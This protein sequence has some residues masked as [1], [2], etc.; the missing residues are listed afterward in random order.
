VTELTAGIEGVSIGVSHISELHER[1]FSLRGVPWSTLLLLVLAS[2]LALLA[3]G[4][5]AIATFGLAT[6]D[7]LVYPHNAPQA[8][9]LWARWD[10]EWYLLIAD[11]GY[12]VAAFTERF[13]VPYSAADATGFFPLYPLL[14]RVL[15]PLLG[16]V[17]AGVLLSNLCLLAGLGCLYALARAVTGEDQTSSAGLVACLAVLL[18]PMSF[19]C[20]A[21]YAESLFLLLVAGTLL[22]LAQG[23]FPAAGLVVGLASLARPF[24]VLL[25][26]PWLWEW[27]RQKHSAVQYGRRRATWSTLLWLW[28][29][30][31][32][33]G[34]FLLYCSNLLG[35][36]LAFAHR[37]QRWRG[38]LSGPW[39]GFL[40]WWEAGPTLHGGA[41]SSLEL[42]IVVA[43]LC[44]L[45]LVIRKLPGAWSAFA[46]ILALLPLCSSLW[47]YGRLSLGLVPVY[48]LCGMSWRQGYRLVLCCLAFFGSSVGA[49]LFALFATWRW[50]G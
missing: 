28:P 4:W 16:P 26:I 7:N 19:F 39:Q 47:S 5:L 30:P 1:R 45:P 32:A 46:V 41:G 2:R 34:A 10:S 24:G 8:F 11:H 9:E 49:L 22:L 35:D 12:D 40:R 31:L 50:A 42:L 15:S 38:A 3:V 14:I 27:W 6:H 44:S 29:V 21:V 37:Q 17:P 20:S 18:H 23:R 25:V 48:V 33:L 43:I 36:P 13:S